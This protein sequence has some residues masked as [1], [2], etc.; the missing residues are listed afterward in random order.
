MQIDKVI[1]QRVC[2][3]RNAKGLTQSDLAKALGISVEQM[4]AYESGARR[5]LPSQ[6]W[7]IADLLD[8]SVVRLFQNEQSK[9]YEVKEMQ[10]MLD[11]FD[12]LPASQKSRV[13]LQM[14]ALS[15][16]EMKPLPPPANKRPQ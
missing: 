6:L 13:I 12:T 8:I 14:R 9:E 5:I 10:E 1:G 7:H 11:Q 16:P 15:C 3:Y 4:Q 2:A